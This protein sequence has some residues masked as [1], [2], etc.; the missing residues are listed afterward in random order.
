MW[1]DR[2]LNCGILIAH[3]YVKAVQ[4]KSSGQSDGQERICGGK[5]LWNRF[6][7]SLECKRGR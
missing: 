7:L 6:V 1:N 3:E 4:L 5:D 2:E